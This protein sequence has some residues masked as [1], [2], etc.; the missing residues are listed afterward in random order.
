MA[1]H[2]GLAAA[3]ASALALGACGKPNNPGVGS[4]QPIM[5]S[6]QPSSAPA[7]LTS[8]QKQALLAQLPSPYR[9]ADLSNGQ[10]KIAICLSCHTLTQGGADMTG[11]NLWGVFGRKAG[12]E[13]GFAYSDA[14]KGAGWIWDA[15]R[16]NTW[17]ADPRA[18]L[19]GTKMTFVG[20]A[21]PTD[22]RDVIA[23]LKIATSPPPRT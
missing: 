22:R 12:S 9:S 8:A 21:D 20:L 7:A 17:I 4:E 1:R 6:E 19:P 13:P 18:V 23:Y 15:D 5:G 16:L 14:M 3:L 10:A 11:P 2:V